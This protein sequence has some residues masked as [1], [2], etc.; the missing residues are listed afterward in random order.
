MAEYAGYVASPP[1]NYGE[2]TNGLVSNIIAIDQAKREEDRKTQTEFDKN[3]DDN[4]KQIK[5]FDFS[6]SQS[7][8]DMIGVVGEGSKKVLQ[9]AY[10]TGS[11]QAVNR[12][13]A[14]LKTSINNINAA[15]KS[16]NEGFGVIEKATLEGKVSPIGNIYADMYAD[17][18]NF[19]DASFMVLQDGTVPYVKYDKNGRIASQNSFFDPAALT[20]PAAFIDQNVDYDKDLNTWATNLGTYQ[21]EQGRVTTINPA[22]N[23]AFPKAKETKVEALTATPRDSA[24]FLSSVAGFRGYKDE[25]SKQKLISE[26][27]PEDK[28]IQVSLINGVPQ[29][30]LTDKQNEIAKE[31]A[32]QQIN[33][34]IGIK[35][36]LDEGRTGGGSS[37]FDMWLQ[38]EMYKEGVTEKKEAR[39][40]A[41]TMKPIVNA[42][43]IAEN[44][45]YATP[46]KGGT[47]AFSPLKQ[48]AIAKGNTSVRVDNRNGKVTLFG[49]PKGSKKGSPEVALAVFNDPREVYAYMKND[50]DLVGSQAEF[51]QG[52][53][54]L[55]ETGGQPR[56]SKPKKSTKSKGGLA[57][58]NL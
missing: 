50:S 13:T 33:Q 34:R 27:V 2:I 12:V 41:R 9:D 42:I 54:Y 7:F 5:E 52:K 1:V 53:D 26:G 15:T 51:D 30:V 22:L 46:S 11:K 39:T 28:L 25:E 16:I 14:N 10:K 38:K 4:T 45:F 29:P 19:K 6:K 21:D 3:F 8:N 49:K 36:S 58:D 55:E 56:V 18:M 23:P 44:I 40:Y 24:R 17:T 32:E 35:R 37:T 31:I 57:A 47:A 20:K 48:A 43:E